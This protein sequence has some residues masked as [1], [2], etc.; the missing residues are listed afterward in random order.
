MDIM[1]GRDA[2]PEFAVS[3]PLGAGRL[4]RAFLPDD[5][6]TGAQLSTLRHHI[7]EILREVIDRLRWE[8]EPARAIGTSKNF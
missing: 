5:P 3:L 1:L 6:P 2:E 8:G 7:R 4:T